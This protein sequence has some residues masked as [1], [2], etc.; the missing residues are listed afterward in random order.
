MD[1]IYKLQEDHGRYW[2]PEE[3]EEE[4]KKVSKKSKYH[5]NHL[6]QYDIV[7]SF[8]RIEDG[9]WE[10]YYKT[11]YI[12]VTKTV[13]N[14]NPSFVEM[15]PITTSYRKHTK[16]I[17]QI[18]KY[19]LKRIV[20]SGLKPSKY[21]TYMNLYRLHEA[22]IKDETIPKVDKHFMLRYIGH[23]HTEDIDEINKHLSQWILEKNNGIVLK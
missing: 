10:G 8:I 21:G 22:I 23:L 20:E 9:E 17:Y 13:S 14:N 19:P 6:N 16:S 5:F 2:S 12:I 3:V 4:L 11:R 1:N 15:I 7:L 18:Y